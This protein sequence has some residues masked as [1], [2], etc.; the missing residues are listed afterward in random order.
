MSVDPE[1]PRG[2]AELREQ[3]T[4]AADSGFAVLLPDASL[5]VPGAEVVNDG[6]EP[7]TVEWH[8]SS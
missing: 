7:A 3:Y 1:W 8:W 6:D 5:G 2:V 4:L